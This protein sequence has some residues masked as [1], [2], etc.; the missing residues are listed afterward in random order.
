[1]ADAPP[2]SWQGDQEESEAP[3]PQGTPSRSEACVSG[4]SLFP[5]EKVLRWGWRVQ[6]AGFSLQLMTSEYVRGTNATRDVH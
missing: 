6:P 1:M 5:Q 4:T 2:V 3:C